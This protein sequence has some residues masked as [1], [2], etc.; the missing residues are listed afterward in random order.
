MK[1]LFILAFFIFPSLSVFAVTPSV[2]IFPETIIQGE[3]VRVTI[4]NV[5]GVAEVK[6]VSFDGKSVGV[7]LLEGKV[8]AFL[9]ID[10]NKKPGDYKLLV[11]LSSGEQLEKTV[12]IGAREKISAPLGI[13][14]KL[15]G[16]T[17]Q[18]ATN[19]VST[20]SQENVVL[21]SLWTQ[22]KALWT[23]KFTFPLEN[24]IVTDSY[25]YT[26]QTS[27]YTI[28]H[29]GTDFRAPEGTKIFASNRGV[30]RLSRTFRNYGKTVV[31]DHG[32][33]LF[34]FY[35]HLSK[36][37][38]SE[39]QLVSAGQLIGLS[40]QTGYAEKPHLHFTVRVGGLS[41]DPMK[42]MALFQ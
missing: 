31:I 35:M 27:G 11:T 14:E 2:T 8:M 1:R 6:A 29:K 17:P 12:S 34:T 10:L 5:S 39:G 20:L 7:F 25:G 28:T 40:G 32:Q 3:P 13:P 23:G 33:G 16:N 38:V 26:R 42:F 36:I 9:G 24:P 18:A 22:P 15:G 41:I 37:K 19:L 30:V 4:E 21:N